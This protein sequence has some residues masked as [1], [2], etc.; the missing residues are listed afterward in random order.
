MV[1]IVPRWRLEER[2]ESIRDSRTTSIGASPLWR[3]PPLFLKVVGDCHP[4]GEI[5]LFPLTPLII[6]SE[7]IEIPIQLIT[8]QQKTQY[9]NHYLKGAVGFLPLYGAMTTHSLLAKY[10]AE[11][12]T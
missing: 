8:I 5:R 11:I 3:P 10:F 12:Q 9:C 1:D 7:F 2:P 4:L 6:V